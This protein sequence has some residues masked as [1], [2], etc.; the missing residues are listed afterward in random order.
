MFSNNDRKIGRKL[1]HFA[2]LEY[3]EFI[4]KDVSKITPEL[5]LT[6][7]EAHRLLFCFYILNLSSIA[8]FATIQEKDTNKTQKRMDSM[9]DAFQEA[10]NSLPSNDPRRGQ[11]RIADFIVLPNERHIL[12][13]TW[14]LTDLNEE[15]TTNFSTLI[16]FAYNARLR[17]YFQTIA[18]LISPKTQEEKDSMVI[19]PVTEL[20]IEHFAREKLEGATNPLKYFSLIQ[21]TRKSP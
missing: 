2:T 13:S 10:L 9:F 12:K 7:K 1:A 6:N 16:T 11:L 8:F 18:K 20:F 19:D 5:H 14:G 15:T 3:N 17:N 4:L 21:V